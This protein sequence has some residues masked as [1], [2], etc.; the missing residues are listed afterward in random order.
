MNN[1]TVSVCVPSYNHSRYIKDSLQAIFNQSHQPLELIVI[2]DGS[3]DNSPEII[4]KTLLECPFES[5]LIVRP[6]KGLPATINE[7]LELSRGEFF[8]VLA[9]DDL[10]LPDFLKYRVAQLQNQPD[11]V[12][13]YGNNYL[14]DENNRIFGS[15]M[16]WEGLNNYGDEVAINMMMQGICP[17][18]ST[19]LFRRSALDIEKWNPGVFVEDYDLHLRL[20]SLGKFAFDS[21]ILSAYRKHP[22]NMSGNFDLLLKGQL[23]AMEQNAQALGFSPQKLSEI[24]TE[25]EW[26]YIDSYL[27]SGQ[28]LRAVKTAAKCF[29][30]KIPAAMKM[31]QYLKLMLP[32][33]LVKA[34]RKRVKRKSDTRLGINI[35]NLMIK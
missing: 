6:N 22:T 2:D 9:S 18:A 17:T 26:N 34:G 4:E 30:V 29:K 31:R 23:Q 35:K 32:N 5:R 8:A 24:K 11:A 33:S 15:S 14:I 21:R 13:A 25:L 27:Q 3:S 16:D 19:V 12:L 28:R 20:C 10:W 7:G 1:G